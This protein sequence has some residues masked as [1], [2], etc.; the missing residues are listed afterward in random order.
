M[1]DVPGVETYHARTVWQD[2]RFPVFGPLDD[3]T[4][5]DTGVIHYTAADDLIDGDPGEHAEDLPQYMRNMQYSY[6]TNRG[7]SLGY[8]FAVDWLGGVWQIRGWEYQSAANKN[9]NGHTIPILVL[10]DGQDTCTP[11]AARSIRQILREGARRNGGRKLAV[12]GHGQLQGASTSC[13]GGGLRAQIS[14]QVF[15]VDIHNDGPV[16]PPEETEE[17]MYIVIPPPERHGS[18]WLVVS[19]SVRPAT[20]FDIKDRIPTRDMAGVPK[21]YRVEQYDALRKSAGLL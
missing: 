7:Y 9:H 4:N 10:V 13:P 14:A 17:D 6:V 1:S 8:L 18:P 16:E 2:P 19:S 11:E 12:T 5:N 21:E 20:T 15:N 3:P